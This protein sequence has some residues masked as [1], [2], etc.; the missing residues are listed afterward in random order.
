MQI[1]TKQ[2]VAVLLVTVVLALVCLAQAL[3]FLFAKFDFFQR[4]E[5]ITYDWRVRQATR[6]TA[7][8][9]TNLGFIFMDDNT[10]EQLSRGLL[11]ESFGLLWPRQ[12]YGRLV[13]ELTA[14]E[15]KAVGF[16]VLLSELR[17]DHPAIE[18]PDKSRM[19]SDEFFA[20]QVRRAGNIALAAD[21]EAIPAELFRTN[22]WAIADVSIDADSDGISR[23]VYAFK[24]YRVWNPL[25]KALA[26][27]HGLKLVEDARAVTFLDSETDK[28]EL[29]IPIDKNGYFQMEDLTGKPSES[30]AAR[31]ERAFTELRIWHMGLR[32]AARELGLDLDNAQIDFKSRKILVPGKSGGIERVIPIDGQG[33]FLVD[34]NLTIK[35]PRLTQQ[36]LES[37]LVQDLRRTASEPAGLTNRWR[38]KVIIVGS[39]ATGS[40]LT[41]LSATPLENKTYAVSTLWNVA[42]SVITGR[43]ITRC[44]YLFE[45]AIILCLGAISATVTWT[46]RPPWT[47]LFVIVLSAAYVLA[48]L[49]LYIRFRYW[50]PIVLPVAGALL[51]THVCTVAYQVLLEQRE[52]RRVKDVFSKIVSPDVVDELLSAE[53]LSLGGARR[54][55]TVFFADVRGFTEMT[56]VNQARADQFVRQYQLSGAAAEAYFDQ[57]ARETLATVNVYLATIA[58]TIKLHNGTLDK[59]IGDCV[60]AF[61]GAPLANEQHASNCVRAAIDAQR[62]M[63]AL[64]L[65]RAAEN[66]RR[67]KENEARVARGEP[68]VPMLPLL[69][70]GTGI[71]TGLVTVGLMG[72]DA[73][74]LN[75]TVFG[76]D[77][78]LASRLEGVSGRGRIVIGEATHQE[79]LRSAPELAATCVSL[80]SEKV[81]GIRDAVKIYE[82]P[83]KTDG[84]ATGD[85]GKAATPG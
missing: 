6:H 78:N 9:A 59:Y 66:Q 29:K 46:L 15:A 10:V 77:V 73:H 76:R 21:Q 39:A 5:A 58:D 13:R 20:D 57:Q 85:P 79:L 7:T 30:G 50:L 48:A 70:L 26:R 43:F 51:M 1:K 81:K 84:M 28:E 14:Q 45:L 47:S 61:W 37:L 44:P 12:I 11:G 68:P 55:V 19:P 75:Y 18:L 71:N 67:E 31:L 49:V 74:L 23:R 38:G 33:R 56:D 82:V 65:E 8:N 24:T 60:M 32:L 22:A 64:N 27:K 62:N 42:N 54:I 52:R 41:D 2:I 17:P 40:N 16:D 36:N 34:W 69:S 4:L 83:W 3:P 35:D 63:H 72:S 80:P 53:K 25:F